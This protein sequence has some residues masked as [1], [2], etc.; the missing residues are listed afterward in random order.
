M[1]RHVPIKNPKRGFYGLNMKSSMCIGY[2]REIS[3]FPPWDWGIGKGKDF[4]FPL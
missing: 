1:D 2:T 4:P 3:K